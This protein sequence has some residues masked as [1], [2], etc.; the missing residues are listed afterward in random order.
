[1][2]DGL[3]LE[4]ACEDREHEWTLPVVIVDLRDGRADNYR[5]C[6]RCG[7]EEVAPADP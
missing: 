5:V 4:L 6:S 7:D 1:M 2:G 3:G